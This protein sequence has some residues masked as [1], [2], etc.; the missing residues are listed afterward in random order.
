MRSVADSA[1]RALAWNRDEAVI[2]VAAPMAAGAERV[3]T[4]VYGGDIDRQG[5]DLL[6]D[7]T[8]LQKSRWPF[9]KGDLTA[10]IRDES[11]LLP[12]RSRWYPLAGVAYH[13]QEAPPPSF[14]PFASALS[15]SPP[16][17]RSASSE[18]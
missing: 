5:F 11:V 6:R 2:R 7:E 3:V 13:P 12:P 4:L 9:I 17:L 8:R 15:L 14:A 1:G 16:R 18:K 10:W